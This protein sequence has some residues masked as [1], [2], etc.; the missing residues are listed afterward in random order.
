MTLARSN[1]PSAGFTLPEI[2]VALVIVSGL[3]LAAMDALRSIGGAQARV[4]QISQEV[5]YQRVMSRA[6]DAA[7]PAWRASPAETERA[8]R[9]ALAK[10]PRQSPQTLSVR[11]IASD[12]GAPGA[13]VFETKGRPIA[14]APLRVDA[15]SP[16]QF[17]PVARACR[18]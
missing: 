4:K 2:L 9:D 7:A 3:M 14:V 10:L 11:S 13:L 8:W 5:T 17:D 18:S 15:P 6:R 16:C 12:T 1:D